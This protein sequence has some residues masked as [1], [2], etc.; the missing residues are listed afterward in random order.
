MGNIC[1]S[2]K[3]RDKLNHAEQSNTKAPQPRRTKAKPVTR[4]KVL[5]GAQ[6]L[7]SGHR[8]PQQ[9]GGK[10]VLSGPTAVGIDLGTTKSCVA[11][12][13]GGGYPE[14]IPDRQGNRTTPS[15]VAFARD[16]Q[17]LVGAVAQQS[18][19]RF[20]KNTV[21][22]AK[23][24]LGRKF[25]D[26]KHGGAMEEGSS[27]P[28]AVVQEGDKAMI[29]VTVPG[30]TNQKVPGATV[31][32]RFHPEEVSAMVLARLRDIAE[33]F[34]GSS[35]KDAVV[36]VPATATDAV[37]QA[38]RD[39]GAICGLNVLRVVSDTSCAAVLY[40][41]DLEVVAHPPEHGLNVLVYDLGGGCLDVCLV[42]WEDGVTEV[43]AV[44]GD[45]FLGGEDFDTRLVDYCLQEFV[46]CNPSVFV[47]R[48]DQRCRRRLRTQCERAKCVLSTCQQVT[49][50]VD[51][52]HADIDLSCTISREVFEGLCKDLFERCLTP[53]DRVFR[54]SGIPKHDV[55]EVVL[56]GGASR[57]PKV[58]DQLKTYFNGLEPNRSVNPDEGVACGAA[59][60]AAIL[61]NQGGVDCDDI[62]LLDV[63][64]NSVGVETGN[65]VMTKLI[66][67]NTTIPTK[68][69]HSFT[70]TSDNQT[71]LRVAVF[72]GE[73]ALTRDNRLL[74]E[75]VI[76]G[77][78]PAPKGTQSIE[79]VFDFDANGILLVTA[80]GLPS[81]FG[82][83]SIVFANR[84][85]S[86]PC[87]ARMAEA[88]QKHKIQE[89]LREEK[90][91]ARNDLEA[92][93]YS[94]G[95]SRSHFAA[96]A[97]CSTFCSET[98][99]LKQQV[100]DCLQWLDTL[101]AMDNSGAH[102]SIEEYRAKHEQLERL[103]EG[104]RQALRRI[105]GGAAGGG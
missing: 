86:Q 56:V 75:L 68:K 11:V 48:I 12:M 25:G 57:M 65:G 97:G 24:V 44:A 18:A 15:Y 49:V 10:Q 23:R 5:C 66:E 32:K 21:F 73:R 84:G 62:L 14:V 38:T 71:A 36:T 17:R 81:V 80:G 69:A 33:E 98:A 7:A 28:F 63:H 77:I 104:E 45:A 27:S 16:G 31:T 51:A 34:L 30:P 41:F 37:R 43:K 82:T 105:M 72:E 101:D 59:I 58:R 2:A 88:E 91:K 102:V 96:N 26:C 52:F 39:A 35:V 22:G 76:D 8:F 94:L 55:H 53:L 89:Q 103:R 95:Y 78:S 70:T 79:L 60:Q 92:F 50:E 9:L 20:P 100:C 13:R 3:S 46:R 74:G 64:P 1:C 40:G 61:T 99:D 54:D 93:C 4:R 87:L 47:E 85:L 6:H 83:P 29:E 90:Q 67:R 19:A 42:T